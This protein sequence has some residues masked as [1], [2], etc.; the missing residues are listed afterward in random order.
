LEDLYMNDMLPHLGV[1]Y[2]T[3]VLRQGIAAT[4]VLGLAASLSSYPAG[5]VE[6]SVG[7]DSSPAPATAGEGSTPVAGTPAAAATESAQAETQYLP[8]AQLAEQYGV[9]IT[10]V[11]VTGGGGLVDFRFKVLDPEKARKLVGQ[12]PTMPALVATGSDLKLETSHKMMHAI[13]LQKDAVSSALYP[14]VRGA[15]KPGTLVSVAF[16]GVRVEP[17]TA[18]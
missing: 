10:R 11:A 9:Q 4:L 2:W 12:L 13:R 14:N 17:V 3:S 18:Q 15:V 6:E 1:L 7:A 5:A 16:D 8:M